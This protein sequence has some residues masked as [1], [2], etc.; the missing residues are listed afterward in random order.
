MIRIA[1]ACLVMVLA[2]LYAT[3]SSEVSV[4]PLWREALDLFEAGDNRSAAPLLDDLRHRE[5][6]SR[7][8]EAH[9]LLG[10][11][12][13]RQQRWQEAADTLEAAATQVARLPTRKRSLRR[14]PSRNC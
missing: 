9:F 7:A 4:A 13:Y 2:P 14:C 10:V 12:L 5:G 1:F 6:F 3:A 11:A 8:H